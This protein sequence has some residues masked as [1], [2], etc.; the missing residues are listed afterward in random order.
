MPPRPRETQAVLRSH[1]LLPLKNPNLPRPR[2]LPLL[3]EPLS[4]DLYASSKAVFS[5]FNK[6]L[7]FEQIF[8]SEVTETKQTESL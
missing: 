4:E 1:V 3:W 8:I 2:Q 5:N 7:V 6:L